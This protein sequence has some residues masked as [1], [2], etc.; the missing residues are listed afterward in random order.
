MGR[1]WGKSVNIGLNGHEIATIEPP[2]VENV[3]CPARLT[4]ERGQNASWVK[5]R[6]R[7][8][9]LAHIFKAN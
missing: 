3:A 7:I 2:I 1:K 5:K 9:V 6:F 8:F 4:L